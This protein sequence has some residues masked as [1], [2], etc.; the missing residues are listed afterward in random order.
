MRTLDDAR[1]LAESIARVGREMGKGVR[2]LLT[3]MNRPL[4]RTAGNALEV[5]ESWQILGG[6]G[7]WE[8]RSLTIELA[9]EGL[10]LAGRA[11]GLDAA[12]DRL[13]SELDSGAAR[14]KFREMVTRQGG[15]AS[16]LE[17]P[18]GLPAASRQVTV[19]SPRTG[20]VADVDADK[21]GR[22]CILLGAGRCRTEDRVD[23]A[24]GLAD[25]AETGERVEKDAPLAVVHINDRANEAAALELVRSAFAVQA[26]PVVVS[27]RIVERM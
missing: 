13:R 17:R 23:P 21:I 25:M 6:G 2:A 19:E 22:A 18:D 11:P 4:G 26:T 5:R 20:W 14:R 7:S 15:D 12:R 16:S 3:D 10:V 9:A 24:V 8:L 1:Q 27:P